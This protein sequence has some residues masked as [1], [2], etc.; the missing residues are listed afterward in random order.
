MNA[1]HAL[2]DGVMPAKG[3]RVLAFCT[4]DGGKSG[5]LEL[6]EVEYVGDEV[7]KTLEA[8]NATHWIELPAWPGV[9]R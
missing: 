4:H 3:Q 9:D 6:T 7:C 2:A 1:W 8:P 5:W